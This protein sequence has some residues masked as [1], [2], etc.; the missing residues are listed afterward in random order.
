MKII[1][2]KENRQHK[3]FVTELILSNNQNPIQISCRLFAEG[4]RAWQSSTLDAILAAL[5]SS[6]F[7]LLNLNNSFLSWTRF[8]KLC[9]KHKRATFLH[10]KKIKSSASVKSWNDPVGY[11]WP[12]SWKLHYLH[13][14]SLYWAISRLDISFLASHLKTECRRLCYHHVIQEY[15][16]V[17]SPV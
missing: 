11:L 17:Y 4:T 13:Y 10:W 3:I 6:P 5:Y 16:S 9:R 15:P 7:E 12:E 14:M 2:L 8:V 1:S